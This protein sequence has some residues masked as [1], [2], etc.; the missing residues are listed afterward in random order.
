VDKD[1][2]NQLRDFLLFSGGEEEPSK[3]PEE[4]EIHCMDIFLHFDQ[5]NDGYLTKS[6]LLVLYDDI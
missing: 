2:S 6:D 4:F 3:E 1:M 5:F